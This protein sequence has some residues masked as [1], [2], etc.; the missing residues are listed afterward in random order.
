MATEAIRVARLN[1]TELFDLPAAWTDRE[2]GQ[3]LRALLQFKGIDP[4]RLYRV[5]YHP[6]PRCWVLTQDGEPAGPREPRPAGSSAK[7][8][9]LFYLHAVG[10]FRWAARAACAAL[11]SQS[12]H[13]ALFGCPYQLPATPQEVTPEE[14][15]RQLGDPGPRR[16]PPPSFDSEGG[17]QS[18]PSEN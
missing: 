6:L 15:V 16:K 12:T 7:A 5:A 1:K 11:A 10:Q 14:L 17:W 8:D 13:F 2:R 4:D 9:E 18:R 3:Y